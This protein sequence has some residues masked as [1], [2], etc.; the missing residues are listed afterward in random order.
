MLN[1]ILRNT[2]IIS[3]LTIPVLAATAQ[4]ALAG[5]SNFRVYNDSSSTVRELYVSDSRYDSW[6]ND[7]LGRDV[8]PSGSD[9]QVVF[10]DR[11]PRSCLYDIRA[12]FEDGQVLEDY[13][14]NVCTNTEY[15]FYDR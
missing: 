15:T 13:Q 5:K 7:I 9:I 14:I 4:T 8:L 2:L 3:A 12:V 10:S 1:N 11:S 6:D